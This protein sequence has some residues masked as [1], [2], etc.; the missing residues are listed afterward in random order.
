M[1]EDW[2]KIDPDKAARILQEVNAYLE[3]VPFHIDTTTLRSSKLPFYKGYEFLELTDM[4]AIPA[5][6]KYAI[7][8]SGDVNVINWTNQPIYEVNEKS[9]VQIDQRSV[10]P[11]VK[12]FFGYV[13]GRHGKFQIVETIDDIKWQIEPPVQGRKVMQDMLAP[14]ALSSLDATGTVTLDVFMIFKDS[15]FKTKV[16]VRKDGIVSMSG[17]ELKIEG[18]PIMQETAA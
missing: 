5:A 2:Q 1:S 16:H 3:P 15:L 7:Y 8:K 13:R 18:M 11:Y 6:R 4:S 12:F 10:V 17:E 9:P 14:I